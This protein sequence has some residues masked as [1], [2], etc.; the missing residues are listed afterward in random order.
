[1]KK[2]GFII[3]KYLWRPAVAIVGVVGTV[4]GILPYF[5]IELHKKVTD[6]TAITLPATAQV[7]P[8]APIAHKSKPEHAE[9]TVTQINH[10]KNGL[11]V[12]TVHGN[13]VINH[14]A[15]VQ[16]ESQEP[17][18]VAAPKPSTQVDTQITQMNTGDNGTNVKT[19]DGDLKLNFNREEK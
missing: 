13:A 12:G 11:N 6:P 18:S 10:E 9:S 1:M 16:E 7:L 17:K 14:G 8:T 5:G 3:L 15:P 2:Y 19:V 4:V